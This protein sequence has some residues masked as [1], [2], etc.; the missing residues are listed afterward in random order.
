ML[1]FLIGMLM[2]VSS[3][4]TLFTE[5]FNDSS[6]LT[7]LVSAFPC[8]HIENQRDHAWFMHVDH[9]DHI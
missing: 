8:M 9:M 5:R 7:I 3:F 2:L 6:F 4:S 1:S